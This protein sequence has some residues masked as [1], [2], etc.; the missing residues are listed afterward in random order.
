[1]IETKVSFQNCIFKDDVLAYI[2]DEDSGYTFTASFEE[3]AIFKGCTFE[4]KAMFKY[5]RFERNSDFSGST[6]DDDTTFKYA[7]FDQD[8]NFENTIFDEIATFKYAKFNKNVFRLDSVQGDIIKVIYEGSRNEKKLLKQF[9]N[10]PPSSFASATPERLGNIA[11]S[12]ESLKK[13]KEINPGA[14]AAVVKYQ[15]SSG[16]LSNKSKSM[17]AID[18]F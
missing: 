8:I 3:E 16:S 2:P 5:S 1:M 12:K 6:F 4:G 7:K 11:L 9:E 17:Q 15:K 13:V 14:V 10:S 18:N